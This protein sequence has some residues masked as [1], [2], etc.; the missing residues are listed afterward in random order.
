[1]ITRETKRRRR[2]PWLTS[3]AL[4]G[5]LLICGAP[6]LAQE[7]TDPA[8]PAAQGEAPAAKGEAPAAEGEAPAL[9]PLVVEDE[10]TPKQSQEVTLSIAREDLDLQQPQSLKEIFQNEPSVSVAGGSIA[11]Q[12]FYVHGIDQSK[13][14]VTIDGA[15]QRNN[16]WHHNGNII[17][18]PV[19]LKNVEVDAGVSPADAGPGA[20]AGSV[21]FETVEASD[22]LLEG[23]NMGGMA[24]IGYDTNSETLR[25]TGAGYGAVD[26]FDIL[27]IFT[28]MNGEDYED[29]S[30]FHEEGT[31]TDLI[32]GLGKLSYESPDGHKI[33]LSGE[34]QQEEGD[35]R[36][37]P[38]MGFVNAVVSE[39]TA[40]RIT[41]T[42]SYETTRPTDMF[43][44]EF[45]FYFNQNKLLRPNSA[46]LAVP[47]GVFNSRINSFGGKLQNTFTVPWGTLTAGADLSY[48]D[49]KIDSFGV[50]NTPANSYEDMTN[51]GLYLQARVTPLE[52]LDISAGLRG[53]YQWYN[54]VDGQDF[55][56]GGISPNISAEYAI[57]ENVTAFGGYSYNWGGLEMAEAALFHAAPYT[58]DEDLESVTA[59][60][61]RGG[62]RVTW[63]GLRAEASYFYTHINNPVDYVFPPPAGMRINGPDVTSQGVDA[64]I[65]YDFG[66]AYIGAKYTHTDSTYGDRISLFGDY[67]NAVP[68]QD[69]ITLNAWYRFEDWGMTAGASAEFA[70]DFNHDDLEA[71]GYYD[72]DDYQVVNAFL[73]WQPVQTAPYFT[74]RAEANNIFDETYF[75]RGTYGE[76]F[77]APIVTPVNSPG[78]SFYLSTTLRF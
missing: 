73:E 44:P 46:N 36:L 25:T 53:D 48:D 22:L 78:R 59:H 4:C 56:D 29:G 30:G 33:T 31:A 24:I 13:L 40:E 3:S 38:N 65:G 35:R 15:S 18:D 75:A 60:N 14:N 64:A 77:T 10:A 69:L 58:Y 7:T 9:A 52:G 51:A 50:P 61:A 39:N 55:N 66:N 54:A 2:L 11:S 20:I 28:R 23:R 16:P 17:L 27:G 68:L 71:N 49:V 72:L 45:N 43:D 12:K 63:E 42:L 37:R 21:R 57:G 34:Y 41:A 62:L 5:S 70:L 8:T 32:D 26:G 74:V 76:T 6:A 1:M 67:N 47:R 19:F